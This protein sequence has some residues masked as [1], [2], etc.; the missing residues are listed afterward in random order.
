M[1]SSVELNRLLLKFVLLCQVFV[2]LYCNVGI[3]ESSRKYNAKFN[4]LGTI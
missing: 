4:F 1:K 2:N 3:Q